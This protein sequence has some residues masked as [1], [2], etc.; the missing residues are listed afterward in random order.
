MVGKSSEEFRRAGKLA[1]KKFAEIVEQQREIERNCMKDEALARLLNEQFTANL[2]KDKGDIARDKNF[3]ELLEQQQEMDH[4]SNKRCMRSGLVR[5][6]RSSEEFAEI[7]EQREIERNCVPCVDLSNDEAL[8]RLLN[9]QIS[10]NL[11]KGDLARDKNFT[12][13]LEQQREMDHGSNKRCM[14]SD[15]DRARG[16]SEE[17]AEIV[18]QQ[19]EI[20]RNCV[21]YV[22][23]SKDEVLARLLDKQFSANLS[24]DKGDLSRDKNFTELL[25]QQLEIDHGSNKRC[26]RSDLFRARGSSEKFAEI[27][28][29]QRKIERNCVPCVDLSNDEAL[30]RLLD[31]Q[32]SADLSKD[33]E[34]LAR[35]SK[36]TE[37]LEQQRK[38]DQGSN[39]RCM[40]SDLDGARGS[41]EKF[42]E[43]VEQQREIEK[44]CFLYVDLSK[45]EGGITRSKNLPKLLDQK[46]KIEDEQLRKTNM[47]LDQNQQN[48][49]LA[50]LLDR[51]YRSHNTFNKSDTRN[52]QYVK[53]EEYARLLSLN[54]GLSQ[55]DT[56]AQEI[57]NKQ[58]LKDEEYARMLSLN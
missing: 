11:S 15:L 29:Q 13:L 17:F 6:R 45:D 8:A 49:S 25:E 28:E 20:E 10:A 1:S 53:D 50:L 2:S 52:K 34:N 30:A 37:L 40:R 54:Q 7:I 51:Q 55:S 27:I 48:G 32:F 47:E 56:F 46:W 12:E 38:I 21:P 35:D 23:P 14:R 42:A 22:D 31:K 24:K 58:C 33:K 57:I 41:S 36:L 18:E 16:S 3:A 9:D 44:K 19:R 4:G 5:A 39:K 26:M 43:L